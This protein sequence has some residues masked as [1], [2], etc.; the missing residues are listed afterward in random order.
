MKI[1]ELNCR[2]PN[3]CKKCG[4]GFPN[5]IK[6]DGQ[7]RQMNARSYC[8]NCSPIKNKNKRSAKQQDKYQTIDDIEHK[9]CKLCREWKP[10]NMFYRNKSSR[11]K[12]LKHFSSMCKLCE[13]KESKRQYSALKQRA[14][15]YKGGRCVDCNEIYH[16]SVFDFHHLDPLQKDMRITA[17]RCA[18]LKDIKKELDKCVL[19]CSNCHRDRH[20]NSDNPNYCPHL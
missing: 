5:W 6:V 12:K 15:R 14:I 19:L 10:C 2:N 20:H 13:S 7:L 18:K 11:N 9:I 1:E 4:G 8:L 3:I 16:E 17:N